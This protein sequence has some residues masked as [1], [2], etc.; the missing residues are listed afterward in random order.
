MKRKEVVEGEIQ[1]TPSPLMH[2]VKYL[3]TV[4]FSNLQKAVLQQKFKSELH[5]AEEWNTLVQAEF[6]RELR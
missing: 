5:T 4:T 2:L 1:Q 6:T 3:N